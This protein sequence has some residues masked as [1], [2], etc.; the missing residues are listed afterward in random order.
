HHCRGGLRG[1]ASR[2]AWRSN[3]RPR[4]WPFIL[5]PHL[6]CSSSPMMVAVKPR[7]LFLL[8]GLLL[9]L[10]FWLSLALGPVSLELG[11]TWRAILR[12][13][14]V[15]IAGDGLQQAELILGQIRLPRA[16]LGLLVGA[17]LAVT[18]VAMQGLFRNPLAAPGLTGVAS[19]AALGAAFAIVGGAVAGGVAPPL[20]PCL[21]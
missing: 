14:G 20:A 11:A 19:G 16:L 12:L 6:P 10:A 18:G 17:V 9:L 5:P 7:P 2:S 21:P 8:L 13:L 3:W 15:P 4:A 1:L